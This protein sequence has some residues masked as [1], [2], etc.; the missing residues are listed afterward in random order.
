MCVPHGLFAGFCFCG[1]GQCLSSTE[2]PCAKR[3]GGGEG[4]MASK[5]CQSSWT[6]N[7]PLVVFRPSVSLYTQANRLTSKMFDKGH[8]SSPRDLCCVP[9]GPNM[10]AMWGCL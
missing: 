2:A 9:A 5:V 3:C 7:T 1:F 10:F 8:M 6:S 4:A